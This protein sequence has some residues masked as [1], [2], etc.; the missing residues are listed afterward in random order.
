MTTTEQPSISTLREIETR[1]LWLATR[2]VDA[3]NRWVSVGFIALGLATS[4][5]LP[6][7]VRVTQVVRAE[8]AEIGAFEAGIPIRPIPQPRS[9][10]SRE[11]VE[12][13]DLRQGRS[14]TSP[15]YALRSCYKGLRR[16]PTTGVLVRSR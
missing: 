14:P 7:R 16:T 4:L 3:A 15:R 13:C 6:K 9:W 12:A 1:V 2:I 8:Q 11:A 5:L 10:K